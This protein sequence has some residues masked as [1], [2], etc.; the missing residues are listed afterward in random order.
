MSDMSDVPVGCCGLQIL[1][2]GIVC[3]VFVIVKYQEQWCDSVTQNKGKTTSTFVF[4]PRTDISD[5]V[6]IPFKPSKAKEQVV[7][8][9]NNW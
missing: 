3:I 9:G 4:F 1:L 2:S 7:L 5:K 6:V 8:F